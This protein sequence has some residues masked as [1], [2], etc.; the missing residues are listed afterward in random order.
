MSDDKR[1]D[2]IDVNRGLVWNFGLAFGVLLK[3]VLV[4]G[5]CKTVNCAKYN[6]EYKLKSYIT[7]HKHFSVS[8]CVEKSVLWKSS[9]KVLWCCY[10]DI[11]TWCLSLLWSSGCQSFSMIVTV[12]FTL[13][14]SH[15]HTRTQLCEWLSV[16][17][18]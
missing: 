7:L 9:K 3:K 8:V 13:I 15:I 14:F 5:N 12:A 6:C 4:R 16:L 1:N 17:L 10:H 2:W 11:A 18:V